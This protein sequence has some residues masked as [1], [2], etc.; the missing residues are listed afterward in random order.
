MLAMFGLAACGLLNLL[1]LILDFFEVFILPGTTMEDTLA[2][3]ETSWPEL[4]KGLLGLA[5]LGAFIITAILF[6]M[7]VH[8]AYSNLRPLGAH[9]TDY[10]PGWAVGW[11][12]VPFANLVTPYRVV[13]EIWT[14]SDPEI[15]EPVDSWQRSGATA[16]LG[17]WWRFWILGNIV[18]RITTRLTLEAKTNADLF[19]AAKFDIVGSFL[20]IIAAALAMMVVRGIDRRQTERAT[21]YRQSLNIPPPPPLF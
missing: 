3:G 19:I 8:R 20:P 13:K 7:W 21:R 2:L 4:L 5:Q 17:W 11:F 1:A 10:T 6:L 14:K 15:R 18:D 12:F 16:L 9:A